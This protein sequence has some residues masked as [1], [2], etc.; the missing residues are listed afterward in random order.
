MSEETV[1]MASL[2]AS[3]LALEKAVELIAEIAKQIPEKPDYWCSCSQC[4][5]NINDA[6]DIIDS[7]KAHAEA[8]RR[9][10]MDMWADGQNK[11]ERV[12]RN[13]DLAAA[14]EAQE[15]AWK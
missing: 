4:E 9:S 13:D 14:I 11:R 15:R 8:Q 1:T 5:R 7:A 2:L 3:S 10:D 12:N 6:E